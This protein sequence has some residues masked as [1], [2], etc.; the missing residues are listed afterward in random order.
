MGSPDTAFSLGIGA[1]L[2][3][4]DNKERIIL[5]SAK[6]DSIYICDTSS[7]II[8]SWGGFGDGSGVSDNC[9]ITAIATDI[10]GNIYTYDF[11]KEIKVFDSNGV[12][13]KVINTRE[14]TILYDGGQVN[15][16]DALKAPI[17]YA[18]G[19]SIEPQ[20]GRIFVS[21]CGGFCVLESNGQLLTNY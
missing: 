11:E 2:F 9:G 19:M 16:L 1:S 12:S 4:V 10:N 14:I 8:R 20:S 6:K 13:I 5:V 7:S 18:T 21:H 17:Y 15:S 3:S